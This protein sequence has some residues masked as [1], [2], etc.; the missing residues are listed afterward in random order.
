MVKTSS[1]GGK[2]PY[3]RRDFGSTRL[4]QC[5]I[6][7]A[8]INSLHE[9]FRINVKLNFMIKKFKNVKLLCICEA[10]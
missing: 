5:V 8:F 9:I 1:N 3:L 2:W 7:L 4:T 10:C 6:T